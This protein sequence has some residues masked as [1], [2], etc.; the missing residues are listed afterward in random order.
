M[1]RRILLTFTVAA[2]VLPGTACFFRHSKTKNPLA[3]V[4][5][6][7]P[8]KVLFDRAMDAIKRHQYDTARLT[9]QT[10]INTYPDSEFIA[11]AKLAVGDAWY[12]EGGSAA[13]AQAESEYKDFQTFFPNM[14]KECSEA[15]LKIANIHYQQMD[16]PDR[17]YTHAKRAEDEYRQLLLNYPDTDPKITAEAKRRLLQVQEVLAER[18]FRIGRFY[19]IRESWAAAIARLKTVS[20]TYPLYSQA[21]ETLYMLGRSY[22]TQ[23]GIIRASKLPE[24][25]KARMVK[26]Y[27]DNAEQAYSKIVT[28][29]PAMP[30]AGDARDRLAA[31]DRVVPKPT[32]EAIALNKKEMAS[33][34]PMTQM[35]SMMSHTIKKPIASISMATRVGEP[36]MV[37]P[38]QTDAVA[39]VREANKTLTGGAAA[40][41]GGTGTGAVNVEKV[42]EGAE[43]PKSQPIPRSDSA[44][45]PLEPPSQFNEAAGAPPSQATGSSSSVKKPQ[46]AEEKKAAKREKKNT[47]TSKKKKKKGLGKLNPF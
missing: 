4:D 37:D 13:W 45:K 1:F 6:K 44:D 17:D 10:L 30:R 35:A 40:S 25:D 21:D 38:K 18:E 32:D 9:L 34:R 24:A 31:M 12:D 28:R 26:M 11:R 8:D 46:T 39:I 15:Q 22:E 2:L 7:Q 29:Y 19:Y 20:D 36:T 23:A 3:H 16:Q 42:G 43:I 41:T 47:S 27:E 14:T 5:S 33:R